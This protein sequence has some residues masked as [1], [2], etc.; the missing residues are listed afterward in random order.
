[1]PKFVGLQPNGPL[2][3]FRSLPRACIGFL[4]AVFC[5]VFVMGAY[6]AVLLM[7]GIGV[8]SLY[9]A[10]LILAGCLTLVSFSISALRSENTV[11]LLAAIAIASCVNATVFYFRVNENAFAA[12]QRRGT[13][14]AGTT[15]AILPPAMLNAGILSWT[16][17][18][19]IALMGFGY[20]SYRDFGW[21][22][23]K[24]FG[25]DFNMRQVYEQYL[26]FMAILKLDT[27]MAILNV[28]AGFAFFFQHL[29]GV[30]EHTAMI[31]GILGNMI[32]VFS[33]FSA[34]KLEYRVATTSLL[35]LGLISPSYLL[36]KAYDL[37]TVRSEGIA[38]DGPAGYHGK[39]H[40]VWVEPIMATLGLGIITR[41]VLL[42][43]ML[44]TRRNFG[45]GLNGFSMHREYLLPER[46][47]SALSSE[48][49]EGIKA[50]VRGLHLIGSLELQ[51][52]ANG[53]NATTTGAIAAQATA[54]QTSSL[55]THRRRF[56]QLSNDLTTLRWS[57][58]EYLLLDEVVR[59]TPNDERDD[60]FELH[61]GSVFQRRVLKLRC[62]SAAEADLM[63]M[64]FRSLLRLT[65]LGD[66]AFTMYAL[67]LFKLA[68]RDALGAITSKNRSMGLGFLNIEMEPLV[69]TRALDALGLQT[70]AMLDFREFLALIKRIERTAL[71][72]RLYEK[73]ASR[74]AG[75]LLDRDAV[76]RLWKEEQGEAPHEAVLA[77][78]ERLRSANGSISESGL[79]YLLFSSSNEVADP[80]KVDKI[81]QDMTKPLPHYFIHAS[82]KTYLAK[83]KDLEFPSSVEMLARS[84]LL[85]CRMV[86]LD[87][88]DGAGGEPE[89]HHQHT[90]VS[91]LPLSEAL[92]TILKHA[93]T[94]SPYPL[95][96]SLNLLCTAQQ[97]RIAA[98]IIRLTFGQH[99]YEP[100]LSTGAVKCE[101]DMPSPEQLKYKVLVR[102]VAASDAAESE[103]QAL[104][105]NDSFVASMP[106]HSI[107]ADGMGSAVEGG[108]A[109][110]PSVLQASLLGVKI[111]SE[112]LSILF[113]IG[114][115]KKDVSKGSSS[116]S[117]MAKSVMFAEG[118]NKAGE[119][120]GLGASGQRG[121]PWHVPSLSETTA[122]QRLDSSPQEWI[123]HN[124]SHVS[125]IAQKAASVDESSVDVVAYWDVG[126]QIVPLSIP[127]AGPQLQLGQGKF[128]LNGGCGYV[129]KPRRLRSS[130]E[131]TR[132]PH[133]AP[134]RKLFKLQIK[135]ICAVHLPKAGQRR[136]ERES[137][138][139]D[140]CPLVQE[141]EL[142]AAP[143]VSPCAVVEVRGGT[144]AAAG[145][146]LDECTHGDVWTSKVVDKNG[147]SPSW[148][149]TVEVGVSDPELAVIRVSV[150]DR[151]RASAEP[152]FL[153]Y[154]S[155]PA[156][157][158][159]SGYRNAPMRD[160]NGC[161]IA[162][163][164]MLWH[165]RQSHTH[166]PCSLQGGRRQPVS[167]KS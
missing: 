154:V 101:E 25:I 135:L 85:G 133:D 55:F 51:L 104:E 94:A 43:L 116:A 131:A 127:M 63:I 90:L 134:P 126:C 59:V 130:A 71:V 64:S 147:I 96:L 95:I 167:K 38:R 157:A 117:Y 53:I 26:W 89:V 19:Q 6:G 60:T 20:L 17:L 129:L 69:E 114:R 103:E 105:E 48:H 91:P 37:Y 124:I 29:V 13:T 138:Q 111:D 159:R 75:G 146:D 16:A 77:D 151:S 163:C 109:M 74:A 125:A 22:I 98:K 149:Q 23:F 30:F 27:L 140:G 161:K 153:C 72:F 108:S 45:T 148:M 24:L 122:A 128:M 80:E 31:V 99:L 58:R 73:H 106:R 8:A 78:I 166:L 121:S 120:V 158:L 142:S 11:E 119:A 136:V 165:V 5:D 49:A 50:M 113:M 35:P 83:D 7:T 14:L 141:H 70:N 52:F 93:F 97:Q 67:Q 3:F 47:R 92:E 56:F 28:A 102:G 9:F 86:E 107:S 145:T 76:L 160:A 12:V 62:G 15:S 81:F 46:L 110:N 1:M 164:K 150:W 87:L 152:Q 123:L 79:Y 84:L 33:T 68:D 88:W 156:C 118:E 61:A 54:K 39:Y 44:Q 57:W 137:W 139:E 112:L 115:E 162:F 82:H 42:V 36:Y 41:L 144:F 32:W 65:S 34:V 4:F 132:A 2:S 143:V 21:R 10:S 155:I 18:V 100:P 66:R 40:D